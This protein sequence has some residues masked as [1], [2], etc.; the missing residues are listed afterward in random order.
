MSK[1]KELF[2]N[3]STDLCSV[4]FT[5]GF[6]ELSDTTKII[7]GLSKNGVDFIEVGMPYSD[8]LADGLTIQ[9]SS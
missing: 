4:F 1:L 5:S 8:P 7:E 2:K 6:P 3:K 9:E